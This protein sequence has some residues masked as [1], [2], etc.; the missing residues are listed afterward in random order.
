MQAKYS[1]A[2]VG[3]GEW[4]REFPD[5]CSLTTYQRIGRLIRRHGTEALIRLD[6]TGAEPESV[7]CAALDRLERYGR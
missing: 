6:W 1:N 2:Y 7:L 3:L 5:G 4:Q